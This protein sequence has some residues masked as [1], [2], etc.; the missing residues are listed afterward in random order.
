MKTLKQKK[1]SEETF[2]FQGFTSD[3]EQNPGQILKRSTVI[4]PFS[5]KT[6]EVKDLS[7]ITPKESLDN[8]EIKLTS[9]ITLQVFT[10]NGE[11]CKPFKVSLYSV[12]RTEE[13]TLGS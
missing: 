5:V 13:L 2:K 6:A 3:Q 12:L 9:P 1:E 7:P 8:F 11:T 4:T 10:E